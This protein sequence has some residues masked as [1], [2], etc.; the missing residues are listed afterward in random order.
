MTF[1]RP[2]FAVLMMPK[3]TGFMATSRGCCGFPYSGSAGP[4]HGSAGR[5]L[6]P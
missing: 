3:R 2:I 6:I 5:E 1:S 4:A